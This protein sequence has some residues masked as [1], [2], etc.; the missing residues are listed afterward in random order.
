[1][2]TRALH[3][4]PQTAAPE[5]PA[6][7]W[8]TNLADV[9]EPSPLAAAVCQHALQ[10]PQ[11]A[12]LRF[13]GQTTSYLQ[14]WQA[15]LAATRTLQAV[16][17]QP[18]DRV[19][20]L[21]LND[22]ALVVLLLALARLGAICVP[23]NY[24]LAPA[25]LQA[26]VENA[27]V[28]L[29]IADEMHGPAAHQLAKPTQT[30]A[31]RGTQVL[32]AQ[33]MC[34]EGLACRVT[35]LP[36]ADQAAQAATAPRLP[37]LQG[38]P[39]APVLLVYTSGTTGKPKG[40]LHTQAALCANC[41]M[42]AHA[43]DLAPTDH[44][45]TVL[46]MFHVGGLCIQTLP[47]L[48]AGASVSLHARFDAGAWLDA[49]AQQRPTLSLLVPATMRAVLQHPRFSSTDLSSLRQI[50]A[51]ASTVAD[52]LIAPFHARGVPVCQ[53]YGATETG[54]V[55]IYLQ[56]SDALQQVGSAGKAGLGVQVRLVNPKGLDVPQGSIGELRL[57]GPNVMLQYWQDPHNSAF[58][59]GWF[60]TGDLARQDAQG[61]YWVVGRSKDMIISGGEN[62]YPAELENLL[63]DCPAI[64]EAAVVGQPDAT[65]GEV[66]VAVVVVQQGSML[67]AADV[68]ALFDGK[69]A[70]FKHP[71]RVV[72][73]ASLPKTATGKVQKEA[74]QLQVLN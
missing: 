56:R 4:V 74:L 63:A 16:G 6:P 57:R 73:A 12:A 51:G 1:M 2:T 26:I 11:H 20:Y 35:D 67:S 30:T 49:V 25:E 21:G 61:F 28:M 10:R 43:H 46:P 32:A 38:H 19:A 40:A 42:S 54:P 36:T 5:L 66:A 64:A 65:W 29:L 41:S 39:A 68:L 71:R 27:G 31:L 69:L 34:S 59:H 8:A 14:L 15:V 70:R 37:A 7:V 52:S 48:V 13:G 24:R 18:G 33:R 9:A 3:G 62:I 58:Q 47:A 17:V 50:S 55:S 44:V 60:H 23:L 22:P 45:L 53:V 72:F